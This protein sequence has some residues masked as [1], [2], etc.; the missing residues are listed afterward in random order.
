MND[1]EMLADLAKVQ[2]ALYDFYQGHQKWF[3]NDDFKAAFDR[4]D[5]AIQDMAKELEP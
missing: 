3:P 2:T 5:E 4:A 1:A